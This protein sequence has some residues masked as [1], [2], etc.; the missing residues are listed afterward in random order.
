MIRNGMLLLA[1]VLAGCSSQSKPESASWKVLPDAPLPSE[2]TDPKV[3]ALMA[4]DALFNSLSS[5]L[6]AVMKSDGPAA[7]IAVCQAEAPGLAESVGK[8]H[9]VKIGRTSFK[10]RNPANQPPDWAVSMLKD[11][12]DKPVFLAGPAGQTGALLPIKL[13]AQC[14]MCHGRKDQI[15][16]AVL[17][18]LQSRYPQDQATGF[19]EGDLRGWFWVEVPASAV[20]Q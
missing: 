17:T 11:K 3:R 10:L 16:P 7:A 15:P 5:R 4:R 14:L 20:P 13:Q 8:E 2:A 1:L 6:M 19:A 9:R 12:P 18:V